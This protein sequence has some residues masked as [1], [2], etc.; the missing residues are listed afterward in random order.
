MGRGPIPWDAV[1]RYAERHRMRGDEYDELQSLI[2]A[3]DD[4]FLTLNQ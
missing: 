3:M 2:R 4:E 1:D